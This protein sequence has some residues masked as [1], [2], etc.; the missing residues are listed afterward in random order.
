MLYTIS[1]KPKQHLP[2]ICVGHLK[3]IQVEAMKQ[4]NRLIVKIKDIVAVLRS[5]EKESWLSGTAAFLEKDATEE[6]VLEFEEPQ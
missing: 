1:G 6:S 3:G 4:S 2:W 5:K